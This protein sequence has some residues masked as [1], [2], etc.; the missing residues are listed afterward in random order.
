MLGTF[1]Y[2]LVTVR[3]LWTVLQRAEAPLLPLWVSL[4]PSA[5][6]RALVH[7]QEPLWEGCAL[8]A[9]T[10][11]SKPS[12]STGLESFWQAHTGLL[13]IVHPNLMPL[14]L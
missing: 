1:Y 9:L 13:C 14:R 12:S 4:L 8:N 6:L 2:Y 3:S 10:L 11:V 5:K 7:L